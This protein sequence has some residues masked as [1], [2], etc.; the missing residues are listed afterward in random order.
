MFRVN[1]AVGSEAEERTVRFAPSL[2]SSEL[3]L[4]SAGAEQNKERLSGAQRA[5]D[6]CGAVSAEMW[7]VAEL[8]EMKKQTLQSLILPSVLCQNHSAAEIPSRAQIQ[9]KAETR[10][11]PLRLG[12]AGYL[13]RNFFKSH[14]FFQERQ[15]W[16]NAAASVFFFLSPL[17]LQSLNSVQ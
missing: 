3:L 8:Y 16:R 9:E 1:G 17:S 5:V 7:T 15:E 10:S 11:K 4:R 2:S 6:T 14:F 12:S 13:L